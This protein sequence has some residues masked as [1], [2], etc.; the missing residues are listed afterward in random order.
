MPWGGR[1]QGAP[2][3]IA[4]SRRYALGGRP[5][6]APLPIAFSRRYARR[7]PTRHSGSLT[8]VCPNLMQ[9]PLH[10]GMHPAAMGR[11][12]TQ[13]GS[14]RRSCC[15]GNCRRSKD[16]T[17]LSVCVP[18]R[19]AKAHGGHEGLI[20]PNC[21]R[22]LLYEKGAALRVPPCRLREV[23]EA[24]EQLHLSV[25]VTVRKAKAAWLPHGSF[26]ALRVPPCPFY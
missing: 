15:K 22:C 2:L 14:T 7:A 9:L 12:G 25:C 8:W 10:F 5:Q 23:E 16:G 24:I 4:F 13:F 20:E 11:A 17:D 26:T 3:P 18:V 19:K 1:P 21:Y 6:G